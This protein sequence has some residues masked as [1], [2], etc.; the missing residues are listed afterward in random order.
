[1]T[2][3]KIFPM[4]EFVELPSFATEGSACFDLKAYLHPDILVVVYDHDNVMNELEPDYNPVSNKHSVSLIPGERMLVPT[5][6]IM[7][8]PEGYEV[9]IRP[10]S[11]LALKK[12]IV[13]V[14]SP[15]T[16]D[17]DYVEEVHVILMNTSNETFT[18]WHG[19]RIAQAKLVK[20]EQYGI[21]RGGRPD[22]KTTRDGGF[23][24]TGV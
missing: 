14:N 10:R 4:C 16:V 12:G 21:V 2:D 23:G 19:D 15:G 22:R 18:I 7:D 5:K 3:L 13:V 11:G 8:I 20:N 1:M 9:E 17:S 6:L 24:H